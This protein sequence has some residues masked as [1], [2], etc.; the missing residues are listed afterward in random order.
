VAPVGSN[1]VLMHFGMTGLLAWEVG[2]AQQHPHD[3]V[4]FV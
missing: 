4:V 3:R 2:G 1:L